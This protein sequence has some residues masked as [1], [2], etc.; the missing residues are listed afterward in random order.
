MLE[1]GGDGQALAGLDEGAE[2]GVADL[3]Q[4]RHAFETVDRDHK[5]AGGLRHALDQE[6]AGH[7]RIAGKVALEDRAGRRHDGLGAD[8]AVAEI[9]LGDP[10]DQLEI[11]KA[12]RR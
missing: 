12:H 1:R 6:H 8:L 2:L 11:L 4:E 10:V 7:Q 3:R 5:P 9:D